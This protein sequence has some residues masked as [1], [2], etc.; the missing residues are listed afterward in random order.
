MGKRIYMDFAAATPLDPWVARAMHKA[1]GTY[2][3]PSAP[4]QEG[5]AARALIE[6]A[7]TTI[8]RCLGVKSDELIF[9]ASGT[10]SNNLAIHGV[11]EARVKGGTDPARIHI[12]T[13]S[14]EHPSLGEAVQY[15]VKRGAS[16]SLVSPD[17]N[18]IIQPESVV[19]LV[20][21]ETVLVSIVAVQSEI[22]AIQPLADI[23]R[24]VKAINHKIIFHTDA[25][26]NPLYLDLSPHRLGVDLA[27][28][29]AQKLMGPKGVG[30]LWR[31]LPIPIEGLMRGGK[32]ERGIRPGTENTVGIVGMA[33][34]FELAGVDRSERSTRVEGVRDYF[35][36]LLKK[37]L[38]Q[39]ELNGGARRRIANN[40]NISVP[41]ADGDYLAVLMDVRGVAVSPRSACIA[42][43]APSVAVTSLGKDNVC[44]TGTLRFTL[45]P[46]VTR[47]DAKRAVSALKDALK[48]IS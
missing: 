35:I 23:A 2:G 6:G 25:C 13:S 14:F 12:I 1:E 37:E 33:K 9:T 19:A 47:A 46:T 15:W 4:H 42:S 36:E 24:A 17:N 40:I 8:A 16:V 43:G 48:V 20:H 28:Y 29:D 18:G 31:K 10:E 11:M 7:R 38:P 34:A 5:R 45:E 41:G 21:P 3:N 27:T 32:Q 30:L 26:Q 39:V 22:G 44:A